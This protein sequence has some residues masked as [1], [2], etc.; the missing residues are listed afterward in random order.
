MTQTIIAKEFSRKVIPLIKQA[1]KSIDII[2]YDWLWYPDQIGSEIQRFNNSI[3]FAARKGVRVRVITNTKKTIAI[4][5]Q[6]GVEAKKIFSERRVHVKKMLIDRELAIIGSHNYTMSAF[7]LNY[8][9]SIIT[10]NKGVVK[11]LT[12]FFE[13]LWLY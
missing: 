7:T 11:R 8:E 3:I 4:L 13:N 10:Q 9:V 6:N 5:N 12:K 2:V 1:K